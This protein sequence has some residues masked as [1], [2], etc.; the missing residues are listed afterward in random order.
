MSENGKKITA[1]KQQ[2]KD[3]ERVSVFLDDEFA[4]GVTMNVAMGL[5]KGQLLTEDDI[6]ELKY[7]DSFAKAFNA[8]VRYLGYRARSQHEIEKYLA[9][10]EYAE[11]VIEATVVRLYDYNYLDDEAFARAWLN[12]REILKPKGAR[13][14][15][16]ELKQRGVTEEIITLVLEELNEEESAWKAVQSKLPNWLTLDEQTMRKKINGFLGRRGFN[17]DAIRYVV[18]E[19]MKLRY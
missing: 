9:D 6:A 10:K 4:F 2:Q 8:A 7:G 18:D 5:K 15:R 1:L 16:Y 3:K 17:Y 12:D 11:E 19:A 14:L 13:A